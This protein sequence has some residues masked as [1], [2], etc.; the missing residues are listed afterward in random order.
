MKVV[1][2]CG[3]MKFEKEMQKITRDIAVEKGWC[4]LQCV[5]DIDVSNLKN[6]QL[7]L[8]KSNI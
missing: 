2:I 3:S 7:N 1:T 6:E 8:L 5:Y 4:V